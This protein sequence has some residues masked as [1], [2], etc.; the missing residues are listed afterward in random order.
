MAAKFKKGSQVRQ[1]VP[2][3]TGTV[4]E[5]KFDEDK[6]ELTYHVEFKDAD[7]NDSARWFTE[8]EIEEAK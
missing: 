4:T 8:S 6:D 5:T 3:I 1:V 2:V 7:G